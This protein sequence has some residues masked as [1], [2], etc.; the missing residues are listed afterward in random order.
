MKTLLSIAKKLRVSRSDLA[1]ANYLSTKAQLRTGQLL[2]IP[3]APVLLAVRTGAADFEG[4]D[5]VFASRTEDRPDDDART[6]SKTM[7]R[8]ARGETLSS[9]AA[10]YGTSVAEIKEM[11]SL[12]SNVIQV[13][14]RLRGREVVRP[15]YELGRVSTR[16]IRSVT[17]FV[18]PRL[19]ES[20]RRR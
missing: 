18:I 11:N 1:E 17:P 6:R 3:R 8:V 5:V 7:H 9:I 4:P 19:S 14:Q 15:G 16:P 12:G 2:I 20:P 10:L 13:A